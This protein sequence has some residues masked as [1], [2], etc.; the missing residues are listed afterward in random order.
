M[1]IRPGA[2]SRAEGRQA[3]PEGCPATRTGEG[4]ADLRRAAPKKLES[5][6]AETAA[7]MNGGFT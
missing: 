5:E 3:S 1:A 6:I 4:R 2:R 7:R